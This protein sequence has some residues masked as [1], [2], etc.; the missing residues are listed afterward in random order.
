MKRSMSASLVRRTTEI[1]VAAA[2]AHRGDPRPSREHGDAAL[3]GEPPRRLGLRLRLADYDGT[4]RPRLG[5]HAVLDGERELLGLVGACALHAS[6]Q[7]GTSTTAG[8][9][10]RT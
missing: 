6:S 4:R 7:A 1:S 10:R 8:N 5:E 9:V 2:V 3:L